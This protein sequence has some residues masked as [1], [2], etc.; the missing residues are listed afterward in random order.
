[1][2]A[3]KLGRVLTISQVA[4]LAGWGYHRMLRHLLKLNEELGGTLLSNDGRGS[5]PR[6][7]V[8]LENLRRVKPQ[9]FSDYSALPERVEELEAL[10]KHQGEVID[11][12]SERLK[13]A[14]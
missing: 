1:M 10:V 3:P 5:E 11:M 7:T 6:W 4:K 2:S 12:L 9:W 13:R 14:G 8:T